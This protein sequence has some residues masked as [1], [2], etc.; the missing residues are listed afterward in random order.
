MLKS[1]FG[2]QH[3]VCSVLDDDVPDPLGFVLIYII[4]VGPL[5]LDLIK[6]L[7]CN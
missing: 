5:L 6:D 4:I 1:D 2:T 3:S 7:T